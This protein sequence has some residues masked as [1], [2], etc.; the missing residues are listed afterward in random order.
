VQGVSTGAL[1]GTLGAALMDFQRAERPLGALVNSAAPGLGRALGALGVG[2]LVELIAHP[3]DWV[4]GV[5]TVLFV[6]TAAAVAALPE[7]SPR[8]P[9]ALASLRPHVHVPAPQRPGFLAAVPAITACWA[10]GGLYLSLGPSLVAGVFGVP[11]HLVGS[12]VI[13]A[14]NG[15]GPIGAIA[16]S[17]LPAERG[18]AVGALSFATG[19]TG[20]VVSLLTG[21]LPLF[22]AAAVVSGFGF[23][24]AFSGA[25]ATATRGV[26]PGGRAGLMSSIF[27]VGYLAFSVPAIGAGIAVGRFGLARTTEFYGAAVMVLALVA[28]ASVAVRRRSRRSTE[29]PCPESEPLAA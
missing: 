28:T 27:V 13:L 10:L 2:V 5:L 9:G 25:V 14:M 11:D 7:G 29:Q 23:G 21:S 18:M 26:A 6:L 22:F 4:F 24:S 19:V 12:L 20:T 16:T 1:T 17:R 8:L 15:T 3:T